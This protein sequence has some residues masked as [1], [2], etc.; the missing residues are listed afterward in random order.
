MDWEF[1]KHTIRTLSTLARFHSL[2]HGKMEI[3]TQILK[4]ERNTSVQR[5]FTRYKYGPNIIIVNVLL[6]PNSLS[7]SQG[8]I[9]SNYTWVA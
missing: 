9:L 6:D 5:T 4:T 7:L 1:G 8:I 3:E 2:K